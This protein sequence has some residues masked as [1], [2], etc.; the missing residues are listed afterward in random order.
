MICLSKSEKEERNQVATNLR[1]KELEIE[2]KHITDNFS[3][4]MRRRELEIEI[5]WHTDSVESLKKR[6]AKNDGA[7]LKYNI[8]DKINSN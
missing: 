2:I 7:F 6:M 8:Q 3:L 1:R 4:T 5:R